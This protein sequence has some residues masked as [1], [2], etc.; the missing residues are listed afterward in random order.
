MITKLGK[1]DFKTQ[2]FTE[3]EIVPFLRYA[4]KPKPGSW[5]EKLIA[6]GKIEYVSKGEE[7]TGEESAGEE[8]S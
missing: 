4:I 6:D 1:Q 8:Q 5:L 3:P 2:G 7:S